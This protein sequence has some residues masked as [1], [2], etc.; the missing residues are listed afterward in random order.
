MDPKEQNQKMVPQTHNKA[1]TIAVLFRRFYAAF[2]YLSIDP[3]IEY[4]SFFGG[5]EERVALDPFGGLES[6]IEAHILAQ[7]DDALGWITP[8]YLMDDPYRK[9]LI[10]VARGDGKLL[11]IFRRAG[12]SETVGGSLLHELE[13]LGILRIEASREPPIRRH[14]HQ[15]LP[16]EL[17]GYRIQSKARFIRPF[18][19]FWFGF[20]APYV[21]DFESG[22]DER[23]WEN[24]RQ[25][26]D[27][28]LSL[29]FEHLSNALIEQTFAPR[30]PIISYGSWWDRK[31]EYDLLAMTEGGRV[32]L[33][34]CK[35]KGRK[36][37]KGEL[38]KLQEKAKQTGLRVDTF[39]LFSRNGF[40]K[41]L[42]GMVGEELMLFG[43]EDFEGLVL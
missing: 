14:K 27:R 19:R 8:S 43:I 32:L 37:T 24:Y 35:Y 20:V 22:S 41:E 23:F 2:P 18:H 5:I 39:V 7:F 38:T 13:A 3:L 36:I 4:F 29:I 15:P 21:R 30:D 34:E 9:L 40:S 28:A 16:K 42:A 33:G 11:N 12:L 26:R 31:S 1:E 17:R 6:N 10:A 25:H